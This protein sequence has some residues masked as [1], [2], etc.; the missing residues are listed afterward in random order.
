MLALASSTWN[1]TDAGLALTDI[2]DGNLKLILGMIWTL[3]LRFT[4]AD[5][6]SVLR[7]W[8]SNLSSAQTDPRVIYTLP[9]RKGYQQKKVC[10]MCQLTYL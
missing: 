4:I 10:R 7:E 1:E 8:L 6:K 9:V 3:I 5:I 2:I